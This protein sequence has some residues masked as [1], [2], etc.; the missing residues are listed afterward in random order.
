[1]LE[2]GSKTINTVSVDFDGVLLDLF[3]GREWAPSVASKQKIANKI[4]I[5]KKLGKEIMKLN[6][7]IRKTKVGSQKTLELFRTETDKLYLLTSRNGILREDTVKWLKK[8]KLDYFDEYIFNDLGENPIEFKI[9][10]ILDKNID[11]HIDDN[12]E[13]S[14]EI[15]EKC[16]T[17]VSINLTSDKN[18]I[19]IKKPNLYFCSSWQEIEGILSK[20]S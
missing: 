6:L 11:L 16:P 3:L 5:P 19:S 20:I 12:L 10:Q 18:S 15:A 14:H 8:R 1:M 2:I 17:C 4:T 7:L 13:V 9:K